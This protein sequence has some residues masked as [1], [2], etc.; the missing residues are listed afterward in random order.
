[1][2]YRAYYEAEL[3]VSKF[4]QTDGEIDR[5]NENKSFLG[6]IL[7]DSEIVESRRAECDSCEHLFKPTGSCKICKCFV[8]AKTKLKNQSCPVGKW[9][10]V[11]A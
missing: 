8:K 10:A 5:R 1:M 4:L 9:G 3:R 2:K 11:D 7:A 6:N